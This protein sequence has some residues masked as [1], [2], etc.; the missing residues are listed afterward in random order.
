MDKFET[1]FPNPA[2]NKKKTL[3]TRILMRS[4]IYSFAIFGFLFIILMF[5]LL[6][7]LRQDAG[8]V[9][10]VPHKAIVFID[11]D[12]SYPEIRNDDLFT[13]L[14]ETQSL[15]FYDLIKTINLAALDPKVKAIIGNVSLSN[16]G[17]A[18][19]QDLRDSIATFKLSGKKAYL[20]S[21]G[22][23]SFGKG[24]SEYYLATA[25]DEIWMQPNTEVGITGIDMEVPFVKGLL[26]KI[27]V[28]PEF[29]TRH[30]YKN[31]VA[32]LVSKGFS[33]EFKSEM[34]RLGSSL[35]E[36]ITADI[37]ATRKLSEADVK[38]A[39]DDAPLFADEA[40]DRKL[41][42]KVAYKP[43]L[44]ET[45]MDETDA[46]MINVLD[47]Y[48][49]IKEGSKNN[50][51]IAF[52]VVDGVIKEGKSSSNPLQ[53]EGV[54]GAD[55][56]IEQLDVIAQDKNVKALV[57]RINSPGGS[58]TASNEIWYALKKMKE[59]KEIPLIISMSDYAA[60]GGYFLSLAGDY[61]LAE[62]ATVTGSIGVLGGKMVM[63][64]LWEKFDI[65]WGEIKF[66]E[67]AGILSSN[68]K[69][70]ESEKAVFNRSLDNIYKDFTAKV[71]EA[72]GID[73]NALDKIA[74]GRVWTGEGALGVGLVD[75][76]GGINEAVAK[77]KEMGGIKPKTS[78]NITYYPKKKTLQ[79]KL[80]QILDG[81]PKIS[82]NKVVNDLG[83]EVKDINIL[84]RMNY[85]A[86]L[87]PFKLSY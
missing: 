54:A 67:N 73:L 58:Y 85:N 71:S 48:L 65:N 86:V 69:F 35:Y 26:D 24:T 77:A 63:K 75:A 23:G 49:N 12:E 15:S 16:L 37:A 33:P 9:K 79:E 57:L 30:E 76:L 11:F 84:K 32:S 4:V 80:A 72:R 70:S 68:R 13:E 64:G 3:A 45:V 74:R 5:V 52:M 14:A 81:G 34:E 51:T 39:V 60:S 2:R 78:F 18:Q 61:V 21:T 25:F 56:I 41:I 66:G 40:L 19:I 50:P 83:F 82:V 47:Y 55:S 22:F 46:E 38:Q 43:E 44:I 27:G 62:P 6:G 10:K 42:D 36:R 87:P 53:G 1:P 7:M 31:A 29:Y 28:E 20:Y 59:K 8:V 17:L